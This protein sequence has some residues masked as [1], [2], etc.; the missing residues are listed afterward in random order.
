MY[1]PGMTATAADGKVVSIHYTLKDDDGEVVDSSSGGEPLEYLHGAGNIVP[2]LEAAMKGKT[3]GDK[4][5]VKVPPAD[6]YGEVVG[7][8]PRPVPRSA[9]PDDVEIEEGMQFFVRGP[10]G[11]PFPV[12]VAEVSDEQVLIDANHPLAGENLNF[13]VEVVGIRDATEEE[14]EHGHPHGPEGHHHHH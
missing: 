8:G 5:N 4:F 2:G 13:E 6:G 11:E 10:D 12:W 14:V 7:N 9:F 3:I 1:S